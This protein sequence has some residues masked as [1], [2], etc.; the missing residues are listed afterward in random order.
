MRSAFVLAV[1]SLGLVLA[2]SC[3]SKSST[4][5]ADGVVVGDCPECDSPLFCCLKRVGAQVEGTCTAMNDCT[6]G[7]IVACEGPD[8][9]GANLCCAT[10]PSGGAPASSICAATCAA[11]AKQVC[12]SGEGVGADDPVIP[13]DADCAGVGTGSCEEA[14]GTPLAIF[15]VC[16]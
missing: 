11:T 8:D 3:S 9:C 4:A 14:P 13:N 1:L 15:G 7:A 6:G 5:P 12:S 10:V 2:P 16:N